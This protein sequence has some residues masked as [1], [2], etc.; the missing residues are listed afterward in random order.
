MNW[1]SSLA[2]A[3]CQV[4]GWHMGEE[5]SAGQAVTSPKA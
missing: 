1:D 4:L 2:M 5:Q 3:L